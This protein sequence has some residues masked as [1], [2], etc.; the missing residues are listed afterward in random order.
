MAEIAH[1][2]SHTSLLAT[3]ANHA[4]DAGIPVIAAAGNEGPTAGSITSPGNAHRALAIGALDVKTP[5]GTET[6]SG[7]GPTD[8]LRVKPD[9][10]APTNTWAAS[11]ASTS[12]LKFY[13]G[14]S[15]ATPYAGAA[16]A[17][18]QGYLSEHMTSVSP[19]LVYAFMIMSGNLSLIT[20]VMGAGMISMP[21]PTESTLI[22]GATTLSNSGVTTITLP[23]AYA[24]E[25]I[26][27]AIWWPDPINSIN[28]RISLHVTRPAGSTVTS[29]RNNA[30][31]Q[32][33]SMVSSKIGFWEVAIEGTAVTGT[34][35]VFYAIAIE[36]NP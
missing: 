22:W 14:T 21:N 7:R 1:V 3:H 30:V 16:A 29:N 6:Y 31:W 23:S 12:A 20:N 2:A 11:T 17:M 33:V 18:A 4:Y 15:G 24:S 35:E 8:D 13:S 27:A 10:I 25:H 19:G 5:A 32:K 36:P 34:Q 28:N 9:L 26:R